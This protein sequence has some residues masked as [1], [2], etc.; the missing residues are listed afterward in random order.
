MGVM[1]YLHDIV[2]RI[3]LLRFNQQNVFV[4]YNCCRH[5]CL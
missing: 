2:L 3:I 4:S 5:Q 1:L